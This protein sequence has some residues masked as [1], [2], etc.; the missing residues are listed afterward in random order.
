MELPIKVELFVCD[1]SEDDPKI[2]LLKRTKKEGGFWQPITGTIEFEESI[3]DCII[4]ELS[5]ETGIDK[6]KSISPEIYRFHWK[7]KNYIVVELVYIIDTKQ[8]NVIISKEHSSFQWVSVKNA[9]KLLKKQNNRKALEC[10]C[11]FIKH[12]KEGG[13]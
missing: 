8:K 9:K 5:E 3:K 4:R 13:D 11:S 12:K 7:K 2:L 6:I 1:R 10:F